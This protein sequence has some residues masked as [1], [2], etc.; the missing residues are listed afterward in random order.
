MEQS[1]WVEKGGALTKT[2][3]FATFPEGIAFVDRVAAVAEAQ[4]H[5]PDIDIRYTTITFTLSTHDA[6]GTLTEKDRALAR[7]IDALPL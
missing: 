2:F 5:H 4:Q 7:A 1:D 6:G 3:S